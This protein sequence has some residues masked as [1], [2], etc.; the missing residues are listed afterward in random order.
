[1]PSRAGTQSAANSDVDMDQ[2]SNAADTRKRKA[3]ASRAS[4]A[5]KAAPARRRGSK[6]GSINNNNGGSATPVRE[7]GTSGAQLQGERDE[8]LDA[9][10]D[11][12]E[13]DDEDGPKANLTGRGKPGKSKYVYTNL[14]RSSRICCLLSI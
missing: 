3:P 10:E 4:S 5:K 11:D 6:A 12:D 8:S 9:E 7:D 2:Q 14:R 1:M 13:D